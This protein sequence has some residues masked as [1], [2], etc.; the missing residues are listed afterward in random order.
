MWRVGISQDT[1]NAAS[2]PPSL[3]FAHSHH[4]SPFFSLSLFTFR[5]LARNS[6]RPLLHI[7]PHRPFKFHQRA[8]NRNRIRIKLQRCA[9][10]ACE[11]KA[12]V[13]LCGLINPFP[14]PFSFPALHGTARSRF[15]F[16]LWDIYHHRSALQCTPSLP[17]LDTLMSQ[18]NDSKD[19]YG[20]LKAVRGAFVALYRR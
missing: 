15:L 19:F 17:D 9:F 8:R 20:F 12:P 13:P 3:W 14:R 18:L 10:N 4:I 2:F 5:S 7:H 1:F 11:R 16:V 6:R